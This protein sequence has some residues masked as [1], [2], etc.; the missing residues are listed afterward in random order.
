MNF[1]KIIFKIFGLIFI[2]CVIS[3]ISFSTTKADENQMQYIT[4]S[5][6]E[7]VTYWNTNVKVEI[8]TVYEQKAEEFRGIWVSPFA[9]DISGFTQSEESWRDQLLSVL[10]TMEKHNLNALVFHLRT[11]NDALY[12]TRLAPKSS[13]I[14]SA[15]FAK[16]D[17]LT[18]LI[19]ECHSRG[20]EFH[21]WLNP[22]RISSSSTTVERI[23]SKYA[24]YSTNPASR[25]ENILI[26]SNG[27]ILDPGSPAV[28]EY[29]VKVC[30][31][32]AKKYDVDAIHFDDYFYEKGI[33]DEATYNKYKAN[34]GNPNIEDFRRLQVDE[35]I[36]S[37][38]NELRNYN[39]ANQK[40]VQLGISPSGVYRNGSYTTNYK[41]DENGTLVSPQY[42]NTLG[43]SHYD[44]PLYSDTKKWIDNE[45]IDYITPQVY[46]S[47][48]TAKACY[49]DI[50]HWWAQVVK[51]KKVNLYIGMGIYKSV[52]GSD[53]GWG[54]KDNR[55]FEYQL[56]FNQM[57][58]E[59]DGFCLF[60]YKTLFQNSN[61][62]DFKKVFGTMLTNKAVPS[63]LQRYSIDVD[64]VS[65]LNI[66]KGEKTF[67]LLFNNVNNAYRYA[68]YKAKGDI[69]VNNVN[70]LIAVIG[71][72]EINHYIDYETD[73]SYIYGVRA[74]SQ[75]NEYS[76]L[77]TLSASKATSSID[78]PFAKF[79]E[80]S[81]PEN[82]TNGGYFLLTIKKAKLFM[83]ENPSYKVYYSDNKTDW[84]L[85]EEIEPMTKSEEILRLQYNNIMKPT[86]YKV[87]MSNEFGKIESDIIVVDIKPTLDTYFKYVINSFEDLIDNIFD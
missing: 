40:S 61:S 49:A 36:E 45:W 31:E 26:S 64:K 70:H 1:R 41:Y 75:T 5:K 46:S 15:N 39:L 20:I 16:W 22:Y 33:N 18:W 67:N 13:Y 71:N 44:S 87:V 6:G 21:A 58:D 27:A 80:I 48:E 86:Y 29:L 42:S 37:L 19:D 32:I 81:I 83:G 68:I 59:I 38:S 7:Y 23:T 14:S 57:Y 82:I 30:M 9:G 35:F 62:K 8:P 84:E 85:I 56:L 43:Y 66:V 51:Y 79:N 54:A 53:D 2:M 76:E 77:M 10:D 50:T 12:N 3:M 55:T 11:H 74:I 52:D 63:R 25:A 69:D 47:F 65:D 60:Q 17:Y 72:D 73:S 4:N 24:N 78:K 28:R 34:Y